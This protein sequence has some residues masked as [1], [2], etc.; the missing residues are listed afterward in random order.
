L[1]AVTSTHVVTDADAGTEVQF[2]VTGTKRG[3]APETRA[4]DPVAVA[5]AASPGPSETVS[6]GSPSGPSGG[7]SSGP[8]SPAETTAPEDLASTGVDGSGLLV[9]AA[10]AL[11]LLLGAAMFTAVR[12]GAG[13]D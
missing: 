8:S 2:S 11:A 7:P 12:R 1:A 13:R 3:Y 10:L 6:P 4:S 5:S 9:A